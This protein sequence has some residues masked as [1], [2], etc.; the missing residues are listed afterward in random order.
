[1]IFPQIEDVSF[2]DNGER[3]KVVF[4]VRRNLPFLTIYSVLLLIWLGVTGWMIS[5]LFG[6][7]ISVLSLGF[8]IVW[9]IILLIWAYIWFRLGR[10]IWRW[11]QY[12]MAEREVLLIDDE[13]LVVHRPFFFLG[14]TDAYALEHVSPFAYDEKEQVIGFSYGARAGNFATGLPANAARRLAT[15]LNRR[16]FPDAPVEEEEEDEPG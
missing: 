9:V 14:A 1:M 10:S 3:L 8:I 2:D 15:A 5:L 11:W 16:Y 13:T 12:Y 4:P 7:D 6:T